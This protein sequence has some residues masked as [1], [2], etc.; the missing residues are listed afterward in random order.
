VT[1]ETKDKAGPSKCAVCDTYDFRGTWKC[2]CDAI[3]I[4]RNYKCWK[5]GKE[6]GENNEKG[7]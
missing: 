3:N 6:R 7:S 2:E 4:S 1:E 5:C